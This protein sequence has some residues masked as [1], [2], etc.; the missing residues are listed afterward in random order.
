M[1]L[2]DVESSNVAGSVVK[3]I[4]V[5]VKVDLNLLIN[6]FEIHC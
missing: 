1:V 2:C 5:K 6:I 3:T 4:A